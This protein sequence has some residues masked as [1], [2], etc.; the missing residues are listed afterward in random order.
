MQGSK[1]KASWEENQCSAALSPESL[2]KISCLV[3]EFIIFHRINTTEQRVITMKQVWTQIQK[4]MTVRCITISFTHLL[5]YL[6]QKHLYISQR[7]SFS[8]LG[9]SWSRKK[10]LLQRNNFVFWKTNKTSEPTVMTKTL[11]SQPIQ[12]FTKGSGWIENMNLVLKF[13]TFHMNNN[14][15][16]PFKPTK[17]QQQCVENKCTFYAFTGVKRVNDWLI[18]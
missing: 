12:G 14:L 2:T 18:I 11:N 17:V 13:N 10:S 16:W 15:F 6:F 1:C 7:F 3:V 4:L 9:S 8:F 5:I